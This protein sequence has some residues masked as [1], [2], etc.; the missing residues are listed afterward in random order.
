MSKLFIFQ[1]ESFRPTFIRRHLATFYRSHWLQ[2]QQ[3]KPNWISFSGRRRLCLKQCDQIAIWLIFKIW[4]FT[5]AK[6]S[7]MAFRIRQSRFKSIPHTKLTLKTLT[8]LFW[9]IAKVAKNRQIWSHWTHKQHKS[10]QP[11]RG[12]IFQILQEKQW[13]KKR[14]QLFQNNSPTMMMLLLEGRL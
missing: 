10:W 8:K 13:S 3:Q 2:P 11:E 6:I 1:V 5:S 7:P 14:L 9:D 4:P 12:L